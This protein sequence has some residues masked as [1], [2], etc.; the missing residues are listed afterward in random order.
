MQRCPYCPVG[1]QAVIEWQR[2][3]SQSGG[4]QDRKI[5]VRIERDH[6]C[7]FT[8]LASMTAELS[9]PATTCALVAIGLGSAT[10]A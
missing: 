4:P 5:E 6:G 2:A 7:G 3:C 9:I 1:R 10:K 8:R